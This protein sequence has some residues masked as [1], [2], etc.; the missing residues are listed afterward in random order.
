MVKFCGS[1]LLPN[2][3]A[4]QL[5]DSSKGNEPILENGTPEIHDF[6]FPTLGVGFRNQAGVH[7]A[8]TTGLAIPIGPRGSA[9]VGPATPDQ[10]T[11]VVEYPPSA[12]SQNKLTHIAHQAGG[13]AIENPGN[14]S[15]EE[16]VHPVV[17]ESI[18]PVVGGSTIY[19]DKPSN[20]LPSEDLISAMAVPRPTDQG[21]AHRFSLSLFQRPTFLDT[22]I[23]KLQTKRALVHS[24]RVADQSS[25]GRNTPPIR[26]RLEDLDASQIYECLRSGGKAVNVLPR[27]SMK[28]KV[29]T[30]LPPL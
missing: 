29:R 16:F 5:G 7:S 22:L 11:F 25:K 8:V 23:Q 6:Q 28:E 3:N 17:R 24:W 26:Y 9:P 10:H 15:V 27:L 2:I 21:A 4:H 13:L 30:L 1:Y 18:T 19:V 12:S 14:P 20:P